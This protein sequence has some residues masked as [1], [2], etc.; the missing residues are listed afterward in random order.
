[1]LAEHKRR[2]KEQTSA[3][4]QDS[5]QWVHKSVMAGQQRAFTTLKEAFLPASNRKKGPKLPL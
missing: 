3:A 2:Y 1:M 5:D 4:L